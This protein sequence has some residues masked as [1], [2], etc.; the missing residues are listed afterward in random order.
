MTVAEVKHLENVV[1]ELQQ[2]IGSE[3]SKIKALNI[4]I[5]GIVIVNSI[6]QLSTVDSAP[7]ETG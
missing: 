2:V 3:T 7:E 6:S 1:L 5:G 4:E